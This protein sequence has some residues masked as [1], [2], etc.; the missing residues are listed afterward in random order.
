MA[1]PAGKLGQNLGCPWAPSLIWLGGVLPPI[2]YVAMMVFITFSLFLM[3]S[4]GNPASTKHERPLSDC[5]ICLGRPMVGLR[6][7]CGILLGLSIVMPTLKHRVLP[8]LLHPGQF[9]PE[10]CLDK[11]YGFSAQVF[12]HASLSLC[13]CVA[14][15]NRCPAL[16]HVATLA[17]PAYCTL[18]VCLLMCSGMSFTHWQA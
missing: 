17:E 8:K 11:Y 14:V 15:F 1:R 6:T 7:F 18:D 4:P 16:Y 9:D 3:L 13:F 12:Y 2:S 10:V 5:P